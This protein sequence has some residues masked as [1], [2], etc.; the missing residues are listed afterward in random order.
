MATLLLG[1]SSLS[2]TAESRGS[3][4][5]SPPGWVVLGLRISYFLTLDRVVDFAATIDPLVDSKL[6]GHVTR[7]VFFF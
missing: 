2:K 4:E 5:E 7:A 6:E 1:G 3:V